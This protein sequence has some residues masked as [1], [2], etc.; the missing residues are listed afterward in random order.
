MSQHSIIE[1][2]S[3]ESGLATEFRRLLHNVLTLGKDR[4]LKALLV[5][6]SMLSEGKSTVASV[7][8]LTAA[9]KGLKTLLIDADVRRPTVHKLFRMERDKGVIDILVESLPVKDAIKKTQL[10]KLDLITAGRVHPQPADVF[11]A[12]LIGRIIQEMKFYYDLIVIDCAPVIPV[13]DPML[14]AQEVDGIL[15]VVK[16]GET[17]RD[18][19]QRATSILHSST[20]KLLGVIL[21]NADGSLPYYYNHDYYGYDY[22]QSSGD[23]KSGNASAKPTKSVR[24]DP[25]TD[26]KSKNSFSR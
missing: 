7:F 26:P 19:V 5:T 20:N 2:F 12:N 11:D 9:K 4:E 14:L 15:F 21:N 8:S 13:S 23:G 17:Q 24:P 16:A 10:E 22:K 6:S 18:I 1:F 3:L 25:G